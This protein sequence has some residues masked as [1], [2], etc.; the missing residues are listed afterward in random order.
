MKTKLLYVLVSSERDIYLEQAYVSMMSARY[1]MPDVHISLIIDDNTEN[2]LIGERGKILDIISEKIVIKLSGNLSGHQRSRIL[3]TSCRKY[4]EGD[5]LFVD[6]DTLIVSS[7][8]AIDSCPHELAACRDANTSFKKSPYRKMCINH[9]KK[10]GYDITDEETYFNSGVILARDTPLVRDF[11]N[12]WH[13]KWL[14][15]REKGI[16]MDQPSFVLTNIEYDHKIHDLSDEWN[17]QILHGIKFLPGAKIVHYLCTSPTP[18]EDEQMFLLRD[19]WRLQQL[20]GHFEIPVEIS[21]CFENSFAGLPDCVH[22]MSGRNM[23]L[24]QTE[25]FRFIEKIYGTTLFH[26]INMFSKGLNILLK[27]PKYFSSKIRK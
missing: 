15:S 17:C 11:F 20:K 6:C 2:S 7:L 4:V 19:K 25:T 12:V 16:I 26:I 8:D 9:C 3:K 5:F 27:L 13:E 21:D 14:I 22:V 10:I 24:L 1:H 23:H 18:K